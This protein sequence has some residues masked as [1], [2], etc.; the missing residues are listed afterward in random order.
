MYPCI[1]GK[2]DRSPGAFP[3]ELT[4][5]TLQSSER[6]NSQNTYVYLEL[7][8]ELKLSVEFVNAFL[9]IKHVLASLAMEER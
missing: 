3:L 7:L 9:A 1:Q 5:I 6:H 8:Q 2:Y 4:T